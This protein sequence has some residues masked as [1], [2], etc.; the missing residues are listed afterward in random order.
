MKNILI[1]GP[2]RAGKSTL[3]KMLHDEFGHSIVRAD[4]LVCA[5]GKAFPQLGISPYSDDCAAH[6]APFI[7]HYLFEIEGTSHMKCGSKFVAV[8]THF[9]A[10]E[11]FDTLKSRGVELDEF[12]LIGLTYSRKTW[13][14]LRDDLKQ[15][16]T[17]DDWTY[18][19]SDDALDGFCKGS[20]GHLNYFREKFEEYGFSVYDVSAEREDILNQIVNYVRKQMP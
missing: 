19:L 11:V 7:A 4:S 9:A 13:E 3:A 6:F 5:F 18:H 16:D 12:I 20:I 17:E 8:L 1:W 2:A 14:E 15:Y 10:D